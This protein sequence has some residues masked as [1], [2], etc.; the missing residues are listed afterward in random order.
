MKASYL[1]F[2]EELDV[3]FT[4]KVKISQNWK[5]NF[6][7]HPDYTDAEVF[8]SVAENDVSYDV[9]ESYEATRFWQGSQ[10]LPWSVYRLHSHAGTALCAFPRVYI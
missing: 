7:K 1:S 2:F 4:E 8:I 9:I 5:S 6:Q 3:S 10:L